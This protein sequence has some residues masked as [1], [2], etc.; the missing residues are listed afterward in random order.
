VLASAIDAA[1][2]RENPPAAHLIV[3]NPAKNPANTAAAEA[4]PTPPET[5]TACE[6][7]ITV[8]AQ[9]GVNVRRGPGLAYNIVTT[10]PKDTVAPIMGRN[11]TGS[12]WRLDLET[13]TRS[14]Y[15]VADDVVDA[16]CTA[17]VPVVATP[18]PPTPT[19]TATPTSTPTPTATPTATPTFTPT[20]TPTGDPDRVPP[21]V[22]INHVPTTPNETETVAF[23]AQASDLG[24]VVR[25]E[26][27]VQ[28]PGEPALVRRKVCE[29]VTVC[30]YQG[31]PY[32]SGSGTYQAYAWDGADNQGETAVIPFTVISASY[33]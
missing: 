31:G 32:P 8:V 17:D 12:W 21:V 1:G 16:A 33:P 10:L 18:V 9:F 28:A 26:I 22:S 6:P 7:E 13:G 4:T 11:T 19:P 20:P 29:D 15:W 23:T 5:E 25:L 2:N 24:T 3:I 30:V 14:E 27:W